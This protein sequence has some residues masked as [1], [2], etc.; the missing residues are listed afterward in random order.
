MSDKLDYCLGIQH[1]KQSYETVIRPTFDKFKP[2]V[3]IQS[4][5]LYAGDET[6]CKNNPRAY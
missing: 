1:T 2:M 5:Y 3:S 4:V 6:I